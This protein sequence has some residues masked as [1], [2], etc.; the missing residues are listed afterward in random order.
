MEKPGRLFTA[1]SPRQLREKFRFSARFPPARGVIRAG[2]SLQAVR[3]VSTQPVAYAMP[4]TQRFPLL[5][6]PN[7][8]PT[9]GGVKEVAESLGATLHVAACVNEALTL[10]SRMDFAGAIIELGGAGAE[11]GA[12]AEALRTHAA[13]RRLPLLFICPADLPPALLARLDALE[14]AETL[15]APPAPR[16]LRAK[17]ALFIEL[18]RCRRLA[19]TASPRAMAEQH[20][21]FRL[22]MEAASD[23]A[24]FFMDTAGMITEWTLAAEN[25]LGWKP[26]E[27]VGRT[28]ALIFTEEDQARGIPAQEL[29]VAAATGTAKDERWHRR[30][31]GTRF[32]AIGRLVALREDG[33]LRGFAK[34]LRDA[35]QQKQTADSEA[36]FR[37]I[38]DTANEGIW[39]L[40]ADARI[41]M[42]NARMAEM[43]GYSINEMI[44]RAKADF[45]FPEDVERLN[46]L[47]A[48]RRRGR[49]A[50][51]DVRFRHRG[52]HEVWAML[53]ARP[54]VREGRFAGALDMFT[55]V[56]ARRSAEEQFR[57]FFE[58]AA[59]GHY[60]IDPASGR[61]LRANARFCELT[62]YA[63]AELLELTFVEI[64]HPDDR[65][66][67]AAA[68][69]RLFSGATDEVDLEKRFIRRDGVPVWVH[70]TSVVVR[71]ASGAPQLRIS[72]AQDITA[73][74]QAEQELLESRVQLRLAV[75]AAELG[76]YFHDEA[77][78][79]TVWSERTK[80]LLGFPPDVTPTPELFLARVHPADR[81]RILRAWRQAH[82]QHGHGRVARLE[83]RVVWPDGS[84]HHLASASRSATVRTPDGGTT[85]R[86]VGTVRD[87][88]AAKQFE[89]TL[90]Q[91]VAERTAALE[92]KSAQL[93]SFTYTVA[94]DLRSPLRAIS[95]YADIVLQDWGAIL[96][97]EARGYLERITAS[98]VRLDALIRDLLAYS[99]MTQIAVTLEDVAL[100]A[101]VD[102]AL[103]Q[104]DPVIRQARAAITVR[105]PLPLV[106]AERGL[107]EQILLNLVSNAVKFAAPGAVP[108]VEI[109]AERRG[110]A[111]RLAVRDE[112]IGI[113]PAYRQRIFKV[114]ERLREARDYPGTGVGL[115]IVA[116]AAER[117]GAPFGV[118]SE[119]GRG[120]TF[121]IE[122]PPAQP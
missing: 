24:I 61:F 87:V 88:T 38:F 25:L 71:S 34:I 120:S 17:I 83:F 72:V 97:P 81:R 122:L 121:W 21:R 58:S 4:E 105:R 76:T 6:V 115:A 86:L 54:L 102:W 19:D 73:R 63:L 28:C 14:L 118:E 65:A 66:A 22:F 1:N 46:A 35:T 49:F 64:T 74:K 104:L 43:L 107:L 93:E 7:R 106:R 27:I 42:V 26:E 92:E 3:V 33:Q 31:D 113:A 110:E 96:P 94:H 84:V 52:G 30:V 116:K 82:G 91:R 80:V 41:E 29:G 48:E 77:G 44:G 89:R 45:A 100:E 23:Y 32:F 12:V 67:D 40:N 15:P 117:L 75:E 18:F 16:Q 57:L 60:A 101:A 53:S 95:G 5:V 98:A 13:T 59:A 8:A 99:R 85:V 90:Q 103:H 20:E 78:Q 51:V 79:K 70:V 112:G 39:I 108:R 109:S 56:S 9:D 11:G 2:L 10:A 111:F 37:E 50:S 36:K 114:F 62:G 119:P 47:F 69:A 68:Y 55:D